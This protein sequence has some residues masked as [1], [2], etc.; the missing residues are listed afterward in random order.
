MAINEPILRVE[1]VRKS[2]GGLQAI[3][4]VSFKVQKG[5][6]YGIIGP[7]GAG[8]TTLFNLMAGVI[9]PSSGRVVFEGRDVTNLQAY[10]KCKLGMGRTFQAAQ[11]F[12]HHTV[13]E[14]LLAAVFGPTA[15]AASWL[16][17]GT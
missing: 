1:A 6:I 17:T 15:S 8:K 10:R 5:D 16:R 13:E 14:N 4:D 11:S 12:P 9:R 2:F 7:N 3:A